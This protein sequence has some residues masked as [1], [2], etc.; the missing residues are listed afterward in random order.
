MNLSEHFTLAELTA[1]RTGLPNDAPPPVRLK[2]VQVCKAIL[3]PVR[4]HYGRPVTVNSGYRSPAVNKAV[5][6]SPGSQ[7]AVGEAVDFEV[8]GVSN[9]DVAKWCRDNLPAF[10]QLILEAHRPGDPASGWVHCSLPTA[11]HNRQVLTMTMGTH[12]PVYSKGLPA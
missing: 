10:G 3:E 7:H 9:G 11:R 2:L 6:S 4:A 8:P 1:T 5:G 12:G